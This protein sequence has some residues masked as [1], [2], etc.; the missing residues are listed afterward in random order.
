MVNGILRRIQLPDGIQVVAAISGH[1]DF[2]A[3][4]QEVSA[5]GVG[6]LVLRPADK[7]IAIICKGI[8]LQANHAVGSHR[9]CLRNLAT[10]QST[11]VAVVGQSNHGVRVG[12]LSDQ[13]DIS[14]DV[15]D[16]VGIIYLA[17]LRLPI[18][19]LLALRRCDS[20]G[21][22]H[23]RLA[24]NGVALVIRHSAR[25]FAVLISNLV[26]SRAEDGNQNNIFINGRIK[27]PGGVGA[28]LILVPA[29]QVIHILALACQPVVQISLTD[30]LA[31]LHLICHLL[32]RANSGDVGCDI[33]LL[34]CPAGEQ[35]QV[36]VGHG[37]I[38]IK[39]LIAFGRGV[40]AGE[41]IDHVIHSLGGLAL[42][43]ISRLISG[44]VLLEHDIPDRINRCLTALS[45]ET[46]LI[47]QP[48]IIEV[49][50]YYCLVPTRTLCNVV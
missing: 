35:L 41:G 31:Q 7:F 13:G 10:G 38:K 22:L 20:G 24:A 27:V 32:S 49:V 6:I 46:Q 21:R 3:R 28:I 29:V 48:I 23:N 25:T 36:L 17:V 12:E 45:I 19:E 37:G 18:Q 44:Q 5:I 43:I 11:A 34:L 1:A 15:D 47:L 9:H 26:R 16:I 30:L 33:H 40:P 2:S 8:I 4:L 14:G 42:H 39:L 50:G